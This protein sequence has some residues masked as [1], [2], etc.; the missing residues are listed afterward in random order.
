MTKT[1]A[2]EF[3]SERAGIFD[4]SSSPFSKTAWLLNFVEQVVEPHWQIIAPEYWV[5]GM[6]VMLLYDDGKYVRP[7]TNYYASLYAPVVAS[8]NALDS[9]VGELS[10]CTS[11]NF[12]PLDADAADALAR[13]LRVNGWWSRRYFAE[14]NWYMP[15]EPFAQWLAARDSQLRS[16]IARKGKKFPGE[17]RIVTADVDTAMDGYDRVYAKSWKKP[18]PYPAFVRG[19]ARACAANGWLRLGLATLNGETIAAQ[20]WFVIDDKAY[21]YKLAY[22]EAHQQL[23]AGTLLTAML[24]EHVLDVDKVTEVDYLTG[25]DPY[26]ATWMSRRRERVGLAACNLKTLGGNARALVEFAGLVRQ[27]ARAALHRGE[28]A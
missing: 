19:W 11:I 10:Q 8:P 16:T 3:I 2:L 7:L 28:S 21:I 4:Q 12:A 9:M 26:K 25:D 5:G 6:S 24:M 23:S 1:E 15:G 17:L 22:D 27:R 18:E 14:A 13:A 20:F